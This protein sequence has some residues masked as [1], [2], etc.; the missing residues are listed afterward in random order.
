MA[1]RETAEGALDLGVVRVARNAE[2]VVIVS[3][4]GHGGR[5]IPIGTLVVRVPAHR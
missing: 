1:L 5:M 2:H 3:L 4:Y